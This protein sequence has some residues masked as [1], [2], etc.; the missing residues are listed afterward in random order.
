[1]LRIKNDF[2][3]PLYEYASRTIGRREAQMPQTCPWKIAP[4]LNAG[5]DAPIALSNDWIDFMK[6]INTARAWQYLDNPNAGW[7]NTGYPKAESLGFGGNLIRL[8][9]LVANNTWGEVM[10]LYYY[11]GPPDPYV[12]N[13][14]DRPD[15][16]HKFTVV[17]D[18]NTITNP[19][20]KA[21]GQFMDIYIP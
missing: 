21:G 8:K 1:M 10:S 9:R 15:L 14:R 20:D 17:T 12:I 4:R 19:Y 5:K 2:E 18:S 13:Y 11:S 7:F 3:S 6:A 16:I